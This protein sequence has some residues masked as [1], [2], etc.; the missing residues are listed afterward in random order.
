MPVRVAYC[1]PP[2]PIIESHAVSSSP[3][4]R[5]GL[6]H[7]QALEADLR[8]RLDEARAGG[9]EDAMRRQREQGKL[10]ARERV[11]R[12]L[13]PGTPFL[14]IG[15]LAGAEAI[16]GFEARVSRLQSDQVTTRR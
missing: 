4:F 3:E 2:M 6:A 12:L 1:P 8:R 13:D 10:L 14:E 7:M 15:A 9:G 11:E 16:A 5:E